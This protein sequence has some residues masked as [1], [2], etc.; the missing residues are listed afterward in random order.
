MKK[1]TAITNLKLKTKFSFVIIAIVF[2]MCSHIG[3]SQTPE[4]FADKVLLNNISVPWGFTFINSN[5]VLF[6]EKQGKVFRYV[7][8]TNTLTEITGLPAIAQNGQGGLLD[9]ALHPNFSSNSFVYITYAVSATGGQTTALGRGKLVGNQ[10]QNFT[11]LF[12]ALPILNSGSHF[13]SRIVF[14]RNNL[15]YMSVGDRGSQDNAQNRNNHLGKV[16]RFNDDGTVPSSNPLVGVPNTKPEIFSWGNRNIQGMDMNPATG[17]IYAHEHGP[18]GGDELNLIKPNTNYGWPKVTFGINYD[19]S[20]ITPDTTLPGMELPLT[21]W[22]PSIAPSGMTF[23]K[24]GQPNNESDIL[25]GAL[26]GTHIHWLKMKDNKRVSSTRS[27]NGYAR[28]RDVR[29]APDGKLYA[30]TETP[31]RFILLRSSVPII[32]PLESVLT[33]SS[34]TI[35]MQYAANSS[36]SFN[37]NSNTSWTFTNIPTWL[38]L[39]TTIGSGTMTIL[40]TAEANNSLNTRKADL[41]VT[42]EKVNSQ[43]ISVTQRGKEIVDIIDLEAFQIL[44]PFNM[45]TVLVSNEYPLSFVIKNNSTIPVGNIQTILEVFNCSKSTPEF[46]YELKIDTI[47]IGSNNSR[48]ISMGK[49][50]FPSSALYKA[51][52]NV[53]SS[54]DSN[55][56][57]NTITSKCIYAALTSSISTQTDINVSIYP[58]PSNGD[59]TVSSDEQIDNIRITDKLG[60]IVFEANYHTKNINLKELNSG[61]YLIT[62][63]SGGI[64]KTNKLVI[65][66]N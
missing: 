23:I 19:G 55:L 12:R 42:G 44:S 66:G 18:R 38:Q 53:K 50:S 3:Y 28:F 1:S 10:L 17:E 45:D 13:G 14:D 35:S 41:V 46:N 34:K 8:S 56:S 62:I 21:Y 58:N 57:N 40:L 47:G 30:M 9:I 29:Q 51:V 64:S 25:L 39:N 11:E 36:S 43:T 49:V 24:N 52:L 2:A 22:V 5:E 7:I 26:A 32:N 6:T 27:L 54:L 20:P 16:L 37:I 60:R 31:N 65:N 63:T 15:I 59:I 61:I 33:I 4:L 48:T